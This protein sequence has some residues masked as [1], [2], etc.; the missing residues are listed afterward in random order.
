M[1]ES[2]RWRAALLFG[3]VLLLLVTAGCGTRGGGIEPAGGAWADIA[4]VPEKLADDG[5]TVVV[6]DPEATVT[7]HLYEDPRCPYCREFEMEGAGPGIRAMLLDREIR[8]EYTLASFLDRDGTDGSKKAVNA[9]RAALDQGKFLELH[10]KL[11]LFQPPESQDGFTDAYLL[12]IAN[13]VD[14]LRG[15]QFDAAVREMKHAEFVTAS[16]S[17]YEADGAEGTPS[18]RI[19][20]EWLPDYYYR[21]LYEDG[22]EEWLHGYV[23]RQGL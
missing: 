4:D 16:Q 2:M 1:A 19:Q 7:L 8:V 22:F 15:E 21:L 18:M 12:Q 14:G 11:Y 5:T 9:L 3:A 6:G 13:A 17:A 23:E 10:E 20:D